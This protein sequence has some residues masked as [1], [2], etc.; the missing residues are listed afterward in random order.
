MSFIQAYA[1]R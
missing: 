1:H